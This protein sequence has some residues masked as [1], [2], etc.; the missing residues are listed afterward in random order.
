MHL[1][2]GLRGIEARVGR[3]QVRVVL[4]RVGGGHDGEWCQRS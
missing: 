2:R 1:R 3:P 4:G